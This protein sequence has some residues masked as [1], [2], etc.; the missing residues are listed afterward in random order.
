MVFVIG[1]TFFAYDYFSAK[2]TR[3]ADDP[4]VSDAEVEGVVK[5]PLTPEQ[6]NL[7]AKISAIQL[8]GEIFDN[9]SFKSL[10][11]WEVPLVPQEVGK[12]NPFAPIG[13]PTPAAPKR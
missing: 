2:Q 9:P 10:Q 8:N 1:A 4:L 3:A 12:A 13:G 7:L 11:D 6:Q 5:S